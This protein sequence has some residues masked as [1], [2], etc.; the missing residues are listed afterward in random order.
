[1]PAP[2][3]G[4]PPGFSEEVLASGLT[5]PMEVAWAPDG[6]M[7]VIQKDGLLRVVLPGSRNAVAIRD[8]SALVNG[9][10]DRG[11]LGLAVDK[12]FADNQYIYLLFTYDIDPPGPGEQESEGAMVSQ[13]L[14]ARVNGLNQLSNE[15]PI[16]G[17]ET[18]GIC[19]A[20]ANTVDCIPSDGRTHSIGTVRVDPRDGT[21]WVGS[22][23]GFT[24]D[25]TF[26]GRAYDEESMAGKILHI[27]RDGRGLEGHPFCPGDDN[28]DHVCAK[29][30]AKGFRNPFRFS[31]RPG[32]GLVVGDVG[33]TMREEI[34]LVDDLGGK[35]YGWPCFEGSIPTP[36]Y[37]TRSECTGL[38]EP[39]APPL[40]DYQHL[41][42]N[43][44]VGGPTYT[45]GRYPPEYVGSIFFGDFTGRF[46][47]RLVPNAGGGFTEQAF[48]TEWG[49]VA[50]ETAPN[51]DLVS[52]N[53]VDFQK[54]GLG[55]ITRIAYSTPA[56]AAAAGA[57]RS[58]H[59][60]RPERAAASPEVDPPAARAHLGNRH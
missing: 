25:T 24:E 29:V 60:D 4:Y 33:W 59:S 5:R 21:L 13:L 42:T 12:D 54:S 52:V 14:R 2:A 19:P 34:D 17:T 27:D 44:I 57:G 6:R 16:L 15:T 26:P 18:G 48:A 38:L 58:S 50:L 53:P 43:S 45:G 1:M 23:D 49:G 40:Y 31:L 9:Q 55:T 10:R 51:G 47:K 20:P 46:I 7:F 41:T 39:Q 35:S 28:L 30:H 32:G 56:P 3:A 11:L 36:G 8:F 22:G 37:A